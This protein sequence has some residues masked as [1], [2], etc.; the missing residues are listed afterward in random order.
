MPLAR[1]TDFGLLHVTRKV[2]VQDKRGL[3]I[4]GGEAP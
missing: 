4:P 2:A 1:E 3:G